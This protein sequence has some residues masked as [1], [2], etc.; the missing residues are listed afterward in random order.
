ME[1]DRRWRSSSGREH[2]ES[3]F[4]AC[5]VGS[6]TFSRSV[7]VSRPKVVRRSETN[8]TTTEVYTPQGCQ[9]RATSQTPPRGCTSEACFFASLYAM[10]SDVAF[11]GSVRAPCHAAVPHSP[12]WSLHAHAPRW[13]TGQA[14]MERAAEE[15]CVGNPVNVFRSRSPQDLH[16]IST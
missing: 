16:K 10:T 2:L 11:S 3:V 6:A 13:A 9:T 15:R 12:L 1:V 8:S 5:R 7:H 4:R 14:R